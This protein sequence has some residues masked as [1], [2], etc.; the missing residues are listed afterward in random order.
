MKFGHVVGRN[1]KRQLLITSQIFFRKLDLYKDW[2]R[3][4]TLLF[5]HPLFGTKVTDRSLCKGCKFATVTLPTWFRGDWDPLFLQ[6]VFFPT[7]L[8]IIPFILHSFLH[9][10][11]LVEAVWLFL[12]L[13]IDPHQFL[14]N[15]LQVFPFLIPPSI[16][17]TLPWL[18]HPPHK[19]YPWLFTTH[20]WSTGTHHG[21]YPHKW[22]NP[23]C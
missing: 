9:W 8:V 7:Y 21:I 2:N 15:Y 18:G 11:Q 4:E 17:W 23:K 20:P 12:T 5:L 6:L 13:Y 3:L 19:I 10:A 1:W 16:K 14:L 22:C